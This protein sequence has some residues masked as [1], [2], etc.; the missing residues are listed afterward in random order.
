MWFFFFEFVYIVDYIDVFP[1]IEPS[2]HPLVE[3]YLIMMNDNFDVFLDLVGKNFM[4]I[5]ASI[6][7][8]EISLKLLCCIFVL[9]WYQHNCDLIEQVG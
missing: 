7:I 3:A 1:Y 2:L 5:F 4:S 6:F 8:R 9:F